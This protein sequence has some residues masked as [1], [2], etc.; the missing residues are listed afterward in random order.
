MGRTYLFLALGILLISII[1]VSTPVFTVTSGPIQ[2][3]TTDTARMGWLAVGTNYIFYVWTQYNNK[4]AYFK[5]YDSTL[6]EHASGAIETNENATYYDY[7]ATNGTYFAVLQNVQPVQYIYDVLLTIYDENGNKILEKNL[8]QSATI[9]TGRGYIINAGDYWIVSY[10]NT[11]SDN[12][13][14]LVLTEQDLTLHGKITVNTGGRGY[15]AVMTYSATS[16]KVIAAFRYYNT[17]TGNYEMKAL[18]FDPVTLTTTK[19]INLTKGA[20]VDQGYYGDVYKLSNG[21]A[22]AWASDVDLFLVAWADADENVHFAIVDTNGNIVKPDTVV[23]TAANGDYRI[24]PRVASNGTDWAIL[25]RSDELLM[26][27]IVDQTGSYW[28]AS[29]GY[30]CDT[31]N[32]LVATIVYN[33]IDFTVVY[34]DQSGN[35]N[36]FRVT[37]EGGEV[38]FSATTTLVS[39]VGVNYLYAETDSSG[40]TY[41][42]YEDGSYYPYALA[43]DRG[44]V[45]SPTLLSSVLTI[46][47]LELGDTNGNGYLEAGEWVTIRGTLTDT[48][49]SGLPGKTVEGR[50]VRYYAYHTGTTD[51]KVIVETVTNTTGADGSFKINI[52]IPND[53]LSGV[54]L[55]EAVFAGDSNYRGDDDSTGRFLIYHVAPSIPAWEDEPALS[56]GPAFYIKNG[57]VIVYDPDDDMRNIT[58]VPEAELQDL[59]VRQVNLAFDNDYIY[60]RVIYDGNAGRDGTVVPAFVIVF[61]FTP[62]DLT[63]GI[64]EVYGNPRI[65]LFFPS[66]LYTDGQLWKASGWDLAVT[67]TPVHTNPRVTDT[68]RNVSPL[69]PLLWIANV[70]AARKDVEVQAGYLSISGGTVT[71]AV[72]L[73]TVRAELGSKLPTTGILSARIFMAVFA[74]NLTPPS[75]GYVVEMPATDWIDVPGNIETGF[76]GTALDQGYNDSPFD[77]ELDTKFIVNFNLDT[78]R[79]FGYTE[80]YITATNITTTGFGERRF[81]GPRSFVGDNKYIAR[82]RDANNTLYYVYGKTLELY[83]NGTSA[84]S[85]T[86]DAVGT[87]PIVYTWTSSNWKHEHEIY[88]KFAG[89]TD[90]MGAESTHYTVKTLY[91]TNITK[92]EYNWTDVDGDNAI[93]RGDK[94]T[95]KAYVNVWD[96]TAW[97]TVPGVGIKFYLNSPEIYLGTGYTDPTGVATLVYTFTGNEGIVG[98]THT[99]TANGDGD[100]S[101]TTTYPGAT[102]L[103]TQPF[104]VTPAPEP[105]ILPILL[106]A[107]LLLFIAFYRRRR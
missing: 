79:F 62:D 10:Y 101:W 56:T 14:F 32:S 66:A 42:I 89:D 30:Y 95:I 43:F 104:F 91:L 18:V 37:H 50:L 9:S 36:A 49:G 94:L 27:T 31:D 16:G 38:K 4:D 1:P 11:S 58:G 5:I 29:S 80:T 88:V 78:G 74:L 85:Q 7:V 76:T 90:Y 63:D 52:T 83:V 71:A 45:P 3:D 67:L 64:T 102:I 100:T 54:Y 39:G 99:I 61:D 48:G 107:A 2:L 98:G 8:T 70:T 23:G 46:T 17:T 96:G 73:D 12:I 26:V 65:P 60:I 55:V 103:V 72:P 59:D 22:V 40:R 69:S 25:W 68:D 82:L 33:G 51:Y 75:V 92:L 87:A 44:D 20:T 28:T 6:T 84:A 57:Q 19:L 15:P 13:T 53:A 34:G 81:D 21:P 97:T 93:S 41:V 105:P 24:Y 47:S 77:Y 35:I 106:V 86:T